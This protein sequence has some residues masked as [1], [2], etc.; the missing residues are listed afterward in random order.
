MGNS[1]LFKRN[2]Y[3]LGNVKESS[4]MYFYLM[5]AEIKRKR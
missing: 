4:R 2:T 1:I 3:N 5:A